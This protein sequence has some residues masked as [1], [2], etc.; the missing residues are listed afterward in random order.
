M[1]E[2]KFIFHFIYP[3]SIIKL[4]KLKNKTKILDSFYNT[5]IYKYRYVL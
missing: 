1:K 2:I 3:I 5:K 4:I